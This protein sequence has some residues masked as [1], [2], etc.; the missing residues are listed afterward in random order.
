MTEMYLKLRYGDAVEVNYVDLSDPD[1]QERFGE[2][3]GL[4][5]E[6]N[7]GFP[8]VTVNGQIRL[9][10]TA[11]YYHILPMVEEAMAARPS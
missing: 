11:H 7:L 8:L 4:V 10:G 9:V 1:N 2:L 5:E 3:M 6:R